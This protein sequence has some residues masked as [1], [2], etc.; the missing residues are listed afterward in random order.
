MKWFRL[1]TDILDDVKMIGLSD[2]EYRMFTYLLAYASE[3]DSSSGELQTTFNSLSHRF[4]QRF[5]HFSHAIETFQKLGLITVN[6]N[7]YI[8]ITNWNKRQFK[9]DNAYIRVKKYREVSAKRNVSKALH[10]TLPDTDTDK[11]K[12]IKEKVNKPEKTKYLDTVFLSIEEHQKLVVKYGP[13]TTEK[14]IEI[15]NNGIMAKGY[16]YKS[17]YHALIGWPMREAM[18]GVNGRGS[19]ISERGSRVQPPEYTGERITISEADRLRN[20]AR[21]RE[22]TDKIDKGGVY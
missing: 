17:H 12:V 3:V 20:I 10:E 15:L 5:N 18:G 8:N 4:R 16:K 13:L 11:K 22:L 1:W 9:S 6:G 19:N 7:G 14:A 2:Y 21:A